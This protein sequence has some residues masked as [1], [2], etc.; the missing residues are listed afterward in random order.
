[1]SIAQANHD[2]E[3]DTAYRAHLPQAIRCTMQTTEGSNDYTPPVFTVHGLRE[4]RIEAS[5]H[6]QNFLTASLDDRGAVLEFSNECDNLYI[7]FL[8]R[9]LDRLQTGEV[10]E[11]R[12][13]LHLMMSDEIDFRTPILCIDAGN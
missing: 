6:D 7:L 10:T 1:M 3:T 13:T 11:M 5:L 8:E 12:G 9:N 2:F 4:G